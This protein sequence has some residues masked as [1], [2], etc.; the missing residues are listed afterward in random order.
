MNGF[1]MYNARSILAQ[2][3]TDLDPRAVVVEILK[4]KCVICDIGLAASIRSKQ[5]LYS[6]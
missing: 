2:L 5:L 3:P 6:G 1:G 4:K